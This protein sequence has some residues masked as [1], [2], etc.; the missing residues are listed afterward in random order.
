MTQQYTKKAPKKWNWIELKQS[1]M[2]NNDNFVDFV[3]LGNVDIVRIFFF[4]EDRTLS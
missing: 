1:A 3:C 4:F 2:V